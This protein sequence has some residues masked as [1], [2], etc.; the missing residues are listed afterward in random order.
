MD[1]KGL[2]VTTLSS[3]IAP[4]QCDGHAGPADG[5]L[6]GCCDHRRILD[7]VAEVAQADS[8]HGSGHESVSGYVGSGR[9]HS[10]E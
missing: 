9:V 1:R 2:A 5:Q 10:G 7:A 4:A 6:A 8:P 3:S